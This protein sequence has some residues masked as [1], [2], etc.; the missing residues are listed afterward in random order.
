[1]EILSS[2]ESESDE[3]QERVLKS[4]RSVHMLVYWP[5]FGVPAFLQQAEAAFQEPSKFLLSQ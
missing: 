2:S 5:P 3:S 4:G 1:M